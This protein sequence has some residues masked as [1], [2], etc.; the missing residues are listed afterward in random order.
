[1]LGVTASGKGVSCL[2][3]DDIELGHRHP[4]PQGKVVD[5]TVQHGRL[6][7]AHLAGAVHGQ[8]NLVREPVAAKVHD[9][10][11]DKGDN[12]PLRSAKQMTDRKSTRLNS[13]HTVISY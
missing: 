4:G 12:Q 11:E 5:D 8:N 2:R 13:S 6:G 10:G 3:G 1:M 7:L 9:N